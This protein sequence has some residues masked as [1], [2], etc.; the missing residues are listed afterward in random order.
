MGCK[1]SCGIK[2]CNRPRPRPRPQPSKSGCK[3]SV[4][5]YEHDLRGKS[6]NFRKGNRN[7]PRRANDKIS[8]IIVPKNCQ[9]DVFQHYNYRGRKATFTAGRYNYKKFTK[10]FL[11]DQLSSLKVYDAPKPNRCK[12]LR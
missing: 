9:V 4:I 3:G 6:F 5:L 2:R 1:V 8:S 10:R 12:K 11:N 7:V